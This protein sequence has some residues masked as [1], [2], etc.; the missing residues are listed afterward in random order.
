MERVGL[1]GPYV[2]ARLPEQPLFFEAR[3]LYGMSSNEIS[4]FGTYTDNF[5]S[6][7]FLA[8]FKVAGEIQNGRTTIVPSIQASFTSDT[9]RAYT[10]GLGNQIPDQRIELGQF[11]A[12][13][14]FKHE[15]LL[16]NSVNQLD[17]TGGL[18]VVGSSTWGSGNAASV[19]PEFEGSRAKVNFGLNYTML[20]GSTLTLD[21]F[22]DGIGTSG[23]EGYGGEFGFQILF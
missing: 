23:Y 17:L 4:P 20:N 11:E 6:E 5:E 10:D 14:N 2:V 19:V 8:L 16:V 22:Y 21:T 9:Q 7:R 13:L 12:G 3:L 1:V 18:Q 15:V